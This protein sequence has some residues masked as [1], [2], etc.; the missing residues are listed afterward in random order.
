MIRFKIRYLLISIFLILIFQA[1]SKKTLNI[2]SKDSLYEK[3]LE[4]TIVSDISYK[5]DTKAIINVTYLNPSEPEYYDYKYHEFLIGIYNS[6]IDN[7]T[8]DNKNYILKLNSNNKYIYEELNQNHRLF[9]KIPVK[10]P[11]SKYYIVKFKKDKATTLNISYSNKIFGTANITF[12]R[13]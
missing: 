13:F 3:G 7:I 5:N 6:T 1:C 11:Y 4:Y 12:K 2:I 9:N 8:L 10:N